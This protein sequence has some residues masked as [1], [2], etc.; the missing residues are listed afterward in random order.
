MFTVTVVSLPSVTY[1][2]VAGLF[3]LFESLAVTEFEPF[4]SQVPEYQP[5]TVTFCFPLTGTVIVVPLFAFTEVSLLYEMPL[6]YV[7][8]GELLFKSIGKQ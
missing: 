4:I 6:L 7:K 2:F 5:A 8:A 1:E 3:A